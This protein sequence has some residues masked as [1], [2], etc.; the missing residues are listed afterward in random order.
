MVSEV[1][2]MPVRR[3]MYVLILV[4]VEDGLRAF[5]PSAV[6][7]AKK[8]LILVLVEDGLRVSTARN[9]NALPDKS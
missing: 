5:K 4:L 1:S 6:W 8:V 2:I 3:C 7:A 9:R